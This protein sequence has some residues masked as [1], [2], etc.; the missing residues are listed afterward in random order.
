[1]YKTNNQTKGQDTYSIN[2][3]VLMKH[4]LE[5][6]RFRFDEFARRG[7]E[8]KERSSVEKLKTELAELTNC[9]AEQ[10]K[11]I[12]GMSGIIDSLPTKIAVVTMREKQE[13]QLHEVD[14][15]FIKKKVGSLPLRKN[16]EPLK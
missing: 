14:E 6:R 10:N 5:N 12:N 7:R 15:E 8:E 9:I 1:M 13:D 11:L 2:L 3:R 4:V 16:W